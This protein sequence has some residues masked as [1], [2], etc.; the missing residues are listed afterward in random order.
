VQLVVGGQESNIAT[1]SKPVPNINALVMQGTWTAMDTRGG[2]RMWIA[3][4]YNLGATLPVSVTIGGRLCTNLT[5][6]VD[7]NQPAD[8]DTASF[9]IVFYTPAGFG[10]N[11]P[12][13]I[14]VLSA[15]SRSDNGIIFSYARPRISGLS[16]TSVGSRR[17]AL[18]DG[19]PTLGANLTITGTDFS[20]D[21]FLTVSVSLD[22]DGPRPMQLPT[23]VHTDT[24]IVIA[25]PPGDGPGHTLAVIVDRR[26]SNASTFDYTAPIV[27]G[28][29]PT[30][31]PTSGG[32]LVTVTG[33]NFGC[34]GCY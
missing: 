19:V 16:L 15:E 31:G 34:E 27:T 25:I 14:Y 18:S 1:F 7:N 32:T 6:F 10:Q 22:G 28:I 29:V 23:L 30:H 3:G 20:S 5:R 26:S 21:A 13:I 12:V 17:L 4:V 2:Q 11:L 24:L 8:A 9:T 33:T